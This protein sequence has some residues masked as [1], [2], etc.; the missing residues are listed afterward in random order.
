MKFLL[1]Q[2]IVTLALSQYKWSRKLYDLY[3]TR[4]IRKEFIDK[5]VKVIENINTDRLETTIKNFNEDLGKPKIISGY[6]VWE[7][8]S[9]RVEAVVIDTNTKMKVNLKDFSFFDFE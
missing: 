9:H 3:I 8:N 2:V 1:D 4:E 7:N 5:S 6:L